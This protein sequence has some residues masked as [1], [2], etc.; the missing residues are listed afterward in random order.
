MKRIAVIFTMLSM[1]SISL[2]ASA[3]QKRN[4][5]WKE[6]M[7]SEKIAILT[8]EM[9][10]T[11]EE[12]QIFWPV[13]NQV[14]ETKDAIMREVRQAYRDL[15]TA[16]DEGKEDKEISDLLDTYISA[17]A[18]Q[19]TVYNEAV[20]S[21]RRVL[22]VEKVAKLYIGEEKFRRQQIHKL[23]NGPGDRNQANR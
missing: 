12:A 22:P 17:Q 21:F 13:Y 15:V 8:I 19:K 9:N 14:A 16:I 7:M 11:P 1:L 6:R 3:Q 4:E 2:T 18:R 10:L 23:H 20:D 5:G